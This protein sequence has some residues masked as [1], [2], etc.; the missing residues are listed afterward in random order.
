LQAADDL[1]LKVPPGFRVSLYAD[2]KLANDIYC[3]TLDA[4]GKVVVSSRGWVKRLE[5]TDGD[6]KADKAVTLV[7]T[8]TRAMGMCF[9][10]SNNDLYI[11][12]DD[13]IYQ[14]M[15]QKTS[16]PGDT[17]EK[18]YWN[19]KGKRTG[20]QTVQL[21]DVLLGLDKKLQGK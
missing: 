7:E 20:A 2:E 12:A 17:G 9:N 13:G 11:S 3:M 18:K 16:L 5:D 21:A 14:I 15:E 4:D 8:K 6:G 10:Y 19:K 1:G